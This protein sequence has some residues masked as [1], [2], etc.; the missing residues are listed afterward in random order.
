LVDEGVNLLNAWLNTGMA[1]PFVMA[2]TTW[3]NT[4]TPACGTPT[5]PLNLTATAGKKSITLTWE[6]GSPIAADGYRVY[7]EQSGK[8]QFRAGVGPDTLTYKDS[9]L[10]SR[11]TYTYVVTSWNDCDGNGSFD[12]GVDKES[13]VSNSATATAR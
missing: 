10:T 5:T 9:G 12:I 13:S 6:A 3:G 8:L 11:V 2:S 1:E 7:Y 4:P